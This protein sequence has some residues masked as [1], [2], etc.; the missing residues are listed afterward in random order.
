M[1]DSKP[2][3]IKFSG[4]RSSGMML[5]KMLE[6]N[7]LNPKR[8]DVIIF[9]N[10]S[11]EH[12]AT[13]DFTRKI[14]KLAEEKY[15]IPFFWIEY[16]TYEDSSGTY[17]W[18][19][20][21]SYRLTNDQP[22]SKQNNDG[23]RYK[24]EVFEEMI[25]LGGF[26]PS[27]VSRVCTLSM[28]IFITNNFLSDWFAQKQGIER[29]GH[30]GDCPKMSDA[31]IMKT[32]HKNGGSVPESI[33]LSKKAF[34]KNSPFV[35]KQ[36]FWKDWTKANIVIENDILK[37]S[38]IGNKA[39]LYGDLAVDY[40]SV[41]GIRSDEQRRIVKIENRIE[42]AQENQGK[43]LFNQPHGESILAPLNDDKITQEQ[44]IGFWNNQDFNLELP[45]NGL[46][47]NCLYCPLKSKGKLLQIAIEQLDEKPSE[48]TPE[49][50][51]WWINIER[52]YSRD[53]VAEGREI[54]SDKNPK[55]VGFFGPT[56]KLIFEGIKQEAENGVTVDKE[57]LELESA[58]PC[59]CTD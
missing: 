21:P 42:E 9:N 5:M 51:D 31:N 49:N 58:I 41:L 12:S 44:V 36:Q 56:K 7:Q 2:H 3:I 19:R 14:K 23:Y 11:A 50:I 16:Q 43:S 22:Y 35:R 59:N 32:H 17:Q 55:Y 53:L 8:G 28:K 40:I 48:L 25:S 39:Q 24:G 33:L 1:M 13:Y 27:M 47:S 15:N 4:G 57:M 20:K 34:V 38:V 30:Y 52:K 6:N 46:F 37:E 29:L 18:S 10:T 45:N 54:T 26:L